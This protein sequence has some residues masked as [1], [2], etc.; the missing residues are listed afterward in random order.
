MSDSPLSS[1]GSSDAD[2]TDETLQRKW[3]RFA[4][5]PGG[6]VELARFLLTASV[7]SATRATR[8]G[9]TKG[10]AADGAENSTDTDL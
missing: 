7:G 6:D 2:A 10:V 1:A 4:A 3:D 9:P 8:A 5:L